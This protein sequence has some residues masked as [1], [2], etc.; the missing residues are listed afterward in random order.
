MNN[1]A[2]N[3]PPPAITILG[4]PK[5]LQEVLDT[6]REEI[7]TYRRE[8]PRLLQ[9]G[10]AGHYI[11]IKGDKIAGI[12]PKYGEALQAGYERY[13]LERFFVH[14]IDPRDQQCWTF[15]DAQFPDS[16]LR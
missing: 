10:R 9:E 3:D 7:A 5:R 8:L 6:Y 1:D 11:L 4:D 2:R 13:G 14:R 12:W 16:C 15:F